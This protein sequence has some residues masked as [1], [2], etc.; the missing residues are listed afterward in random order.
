M[1]VVILAGHG[2]STWIVA[3]A[4][5]GEVPLVKIIIENSPSTRVKVIRKMRKLGIVKTFG[6]LLFQ[7]YAR[8]LRKKSNKRVINILA[9][10]GLNSSIPQG[11][12]IIHVDSANGSETKEILINLKPDVVV[13]NGTRILSQK[14]LQSV[15]AKFVNMHAGITPKYRGV[16]GGYWAI[17]SDDKENAGVTVHL[18]DQGIDTGGVLHQ[19]TISPTKEDNFSTYPY[20]QLC[21]GIPLLIQAV[22]EL[23][24]N[25]HQVINSDLPSQ[26]HYHPTIWVYWYHRI[27][28]GIQ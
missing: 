22:K 10:S 5:A 28:K 14:L 2:D 13:V 20:L 11:V 8:Y 1:S 15:S 16:H 4:L 19:D 21:K 6:Q 7:V 24:D 26:L 12:D 27:F 18:V 17:V 3:N 25:K 23:S 9:E